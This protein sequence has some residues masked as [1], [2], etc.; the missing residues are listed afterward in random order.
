[1][2]AYFL[3]NYTTEKQK[4][5]GSHLT[6]RVISIEKVI[7]KKKRKMTQFLALPLTAK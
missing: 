6:E 4:M 1:M 3:S 2:V 5:T 7:S